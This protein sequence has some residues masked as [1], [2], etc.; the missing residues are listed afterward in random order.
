MTDKKKAPPSYKSDDIMDPEGNPAQ[1]VLA[2][3]ELEVD[4]IK[5]QRRLKGLVINSL[6][7]REATTQVES[8]RGLKRLIRSR[9]DTQ[10][11]NESERD[12]L[13]ESREALTNAPKQ[14]AKSKKA[15]G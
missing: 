12:Y 8:L 11:Y 9:M 14:P 10:I 5:L 4:L 6:E 2:L 1:T 3:K 13:A 15:K 7:W